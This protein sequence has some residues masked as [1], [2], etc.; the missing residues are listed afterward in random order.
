M[1]KVRR[2]QFSV[3]LLSKKKK[4]R[5]YTIAKYFER[6]VNEIDALFATSYICKIIVIMQNLS[7]IKPKLLNDH[8]QIHDKTVE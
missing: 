8:E 2:V 7:F 4:K 6:W 3:W 1:G 5:F